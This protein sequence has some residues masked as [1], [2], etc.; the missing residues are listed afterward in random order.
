MTETIYLIRFNQR[1][2]CRSCK[3]YFAIAK[4]E[5]LADKIMLKASVEYPD[6][7]FWKRI[8][9]VVME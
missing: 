1:K 8:C 4:T 2:K 9:K 5:A 3:H 6:K 7:L